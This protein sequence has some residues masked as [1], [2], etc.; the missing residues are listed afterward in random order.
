M[1]FWEAGGGG[2]GFL[3]KELRGIITEIEKALRSADHNT[4]CI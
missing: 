2:G 3:A 4:F 1:E